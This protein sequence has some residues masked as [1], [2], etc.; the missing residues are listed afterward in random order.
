MKNFQKLLALV[1]VVAML[2]SF[3]LTA[4]ATDFT[5][6]KEITHAEAVEVM[7]LLGIINGLPDGSFN[8]EGT[9]TRAEMAKMITTLMNKGKDVAT[10]YESANNFT[11]CDWHWAKGYIA[12]GETKGFVAGLG[13]GTFNPDGTVTGTEAAKMVLGALAYDGANEGMEGASWAANTLAL[14]DEVE[15]LEDL[16]DVAM[17]EALSR[18]HA[19]QMMFNVL[20]GE[21][22]KYT[23]GGTVV[24]GEGFSVTTATPESYGTGNTA[25][26]T[27]FSD[28]KVT[29]TTDDLGREANKYAYDG[30]SVTVTC[31]AEYTIVVDDEYT[32]DLLDAIQDLADNSDL[33]YIDNEGIYF[34]NGDEVDDDGDGD[35]GEESDMIYNGGLEAGDVLYVYVDDD[36]SDLITTVAVARYVHAIITDVDTSV[37]SSDADDDIYAYVDLED[38]DGDAVG[39]GTFDDVDIVGFDA[40][41]YVEDAVLAAAVNI[42]GDI[43][44]SYIAEVV[45]GAI[46]TYTSDSTVTIDGTKY[47]VVTAY[48]ATGGVYTS[49]IDFDTTYVAYLTA[50]GYVMALDGSAADVT[51]DD[52][53]YVTGAVAST[54]GTYSTETYY[55]QAV[56]LEDGSVSE[57]ILTDDGFE[58]LVGSSNYSTGVF[59]TANAGLYSFEEDDDDYDVVAYDGDS[60]YEVSAIGDLDSDVS[61][62]DSVI[63][64]NN[65]KYYVSSSTIFIAIEDEG[66]NIDVDFASGSMKMAANAGTYILAIHDGGT[67]KSADYILF[68]GEELSSSVSSDDVVY[69]AETPDTAVSGGYEGEI[70][71][72]VDGTVETVV[73]D[74]DYAPGF[75]TYDI[76]DD[77]VYELTG[78]TTS[79]KGDITDAGQDGG[80]EGAVIEGIFSDYLVTF[81]GG[82]SEDFD[83]SGAVIM[84]IRDDD[85]KDA[86]VYKS[87]INTASKLSSAVGK[88]DVTVDFFIT[89][90]EVTLICVTAVENA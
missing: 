71:S 74:D 59:Y 89:D 37:S 83:I 16:E 76:D 17:G 43:V 64:G 28:L 65:T 62:S 46:T 9:V 10:T 66:D 35:D 25:Q 26:D 1:L 87:A 14:A 47:Y 67:A 77:D 5:D 19:A 63:Y 8:P 79:D 84:D 51:L 81:V 80:V 69:V 75:Y 6:D 44:D 54:S 31:A 21:V 27:Y 7:V 45:E 23:S 57:V 36:D 61:T 3:A 53:Y 56:S 78:L 82:G 20:A 29:S 50:E 58:A 73:M 88:G 18:E 2:A 39:D 11:D 55:A 60:D 42:D 4:S 86:D 22:V 33:E 32:S 30:D 34:L 41:T 49:S 72:A 52:V 38:L 40:D 48:G 85:D 15:L 12:Y 90:E 24:E 70:Y 68:I 13:D